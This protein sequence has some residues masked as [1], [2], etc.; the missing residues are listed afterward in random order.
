MRRPTAI[1]HA[2]YRVASTAK[3]AL[4]NLCG[5]TGKSVDHFCA[6]LI[7]CHIENHRDFHDIC[8]PAS[9]IYELYHLRDLYPELEHEVIIE[10]DELVA[11]GHDVIQKIGRESGWN[12]IQ[13]AKWMHR[14]LFRLG[15]EQSYLQTISW[16]I[17]LSTHF[18]NPENYSWHD[19]RHLRSAQLFLDLDIASL[20]ATPEDFSDGTESLWQEQQAHYTRKEFNKN[21]ANWAEAML[22]REKLYYTEYFA[23]R[24]DQARANLETLLT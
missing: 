23:D 5:I 12:E 18:R 1:G 21:A 20:G 16:T 3:E 24:E 19:E 7:S 8:H 13:S 15:V 6:E 14:R 17:E 9:I 22:A 4:K 2:S 11:V 10:I